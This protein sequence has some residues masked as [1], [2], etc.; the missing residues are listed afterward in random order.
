MAAFPP[1]ISLLGDNGEAVLSFAIGKRAVSVEVGAADPSEEGDAQDKEQAE[2]ERQPCL[3]GWRPVGGAAD[4]P[5]LWCVSS[6]RSAAESAKNPASAVAPLP[7]AEAV[8]SALRMQPGLLVWVRKGTT[9]RAYVRPGDGGS[10]APTPT[11]AASAEAPLGSS[12]DGHSSQP[13]DGGHA[14]ADGTSSADVSPGRAVRTRDRYSQAVAFEFVTDV[15]S[16]LFS[17]GDDGDPSASSP[18]P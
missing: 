6:L 15:M 4:S 8:L 17:S 7:N 5:F 16:G 10:A 3:V 11:K 13:A 1:V 12:G 18:P 2:L 14:G 9:F